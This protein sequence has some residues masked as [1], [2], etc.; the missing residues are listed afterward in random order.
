MVILVPVMIRPSQAVEASEVEEAS[1]V[2][3]AGEVSKAWKIPTEDFRVFLVLKFNNL[4][5][6]ITFF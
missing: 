5:T 4:R 2:N 6:S 3:E 1:E